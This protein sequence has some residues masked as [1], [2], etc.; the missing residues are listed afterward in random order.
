MPMFP[1][2]RSTKSAMFKHGALALA[3]AC[4]TGSAL[5]ATPAMAAKKEAAPPKASY[6]KP[7]IAA[8]IPA[9]KAIEAAGKRPDV[10]AASQAGKAAIDAYN[11]A[12]TSAGRKTAEDQRLA[13]I[14]T[15]S[16][17][18]TEEKRLL[19]AALAAITVPDDK[20]F[21][22]QLAINLGTTAQ[23]ET[24]QRRGVQLMIDSGK[25]APAELPKMYFYLGQF[26]A[27]TKD[28]TSAIA[29]YQTAI[30]AGY[31]EN[32]I[33]VSLAEA[34]LS[35][36]Q[37]PTGLAKLQAAID[38]RNATGSPAPESWYRRGL[39]MAYK[40][41]LYDSAATF[42]RNAVAVY[43]TPD[44]WEAAIGMLRITGKYQ[45]QESLDLMRLM[46]RTK[47]MNQSSDYVE[48]LQAADAR[49]L[50]GEVLKVLDAGI[51][52]GKL[53]ASDVFV[54]ENRGIAQSRLAADKVAMPALERDARAAGASAVTVMAAGD[55]FLSYDQ[56]AKAKEM[57]TLALGKPGVDT[58]RALTRLGIAQC[59]LGSY[60]EAQATFAK[61]TGP[62]QPLAQLWAIHSA[63]KAKSGT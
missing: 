43:P 36:N 19:D 61:I 14:A 6:S 39:Q 50:P 32:G 33:D 20:L 27:S 41:K 47:S 40:A 45:A 51:A 21:A 11:A 46:A 57:Y 63:Q 7:F 60:A 12:T 8:V 26:S 62:R 34:Y 35:S 31:H 24:M 13:A 1:V 54:S 59:D 18:L 37:I 3:L 38:Q 23:D 49:R 28:Y 15:L 55:V 30:D 42:S 2:V 53:T 16:G 17:L 5:V 29:A 56:P 44:N 9:Q 52:S 22:G 4:A 48:Y 10:A 25:L 58:A